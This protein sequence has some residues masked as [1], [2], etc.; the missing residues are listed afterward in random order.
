MGKS[1]KDTPQYSVLE[2]EIQTTRGP[3]NY[4]VSTERDGYT[5]VEDVWADEAEIEQ[6][7]L[8]FY[9]RQSRIAPEKKTWFTR[10]TGRITL[11]VHEQREL[12]AAYGR[13]SWD[14]FGLAED[15]EGDPNR[16]YGILDL[17][18]EGD[19]DDT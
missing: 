10:L 14:S 19:D 4:I 9:R 1:I 12:V 17:R 11:R 7:E 16:E 18:R 2:A 8:R 6:G 13:S 15:P 5:L 3:K